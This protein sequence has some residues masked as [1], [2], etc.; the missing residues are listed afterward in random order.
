MNFKPIYLFLSLLL[1]SLTTQAQKYTQD[2]ILNDQAYTQTPFISLEGAKSDNLTVNISLKSYAP[3]PK[4]QEGLTGVSWATTYAAFSIEKNIEKGL[5]DSPTLNELAYSPYF[6]QAYLPVSK[7]DARY[8]QEINDA[9]D[10]L[11][12]KG[13]VNLSEYKPSPHL[14]P[15]SKGL[16]FKAQ[17]QS[18]IRYERLFDINC[19]EKQK[20]DRIRLM[21][22][23]NHPVILAVNMTGNFKDNDTIWHPNQGDQTENYHCLVAIGYDILDHQFELMNSWG[24]DWKNKGFCY[25]NETEL[26]KV[27]RYAYIIHL[28]EPPTSSSSPLFTIKPI[29]PRNPL[30][31][32]HQSQLLYTSASD[33]PLKQIYQ[34]ISSRRPTEAYIYVWSIDPNGKLTHHYPLNSNAS[35]DYS[36]HRSITIP[37]PKDAMRITQKG[38]DHIFILY[39]QSPIHNHHQIAQ[40]LQ[41]LHQKSSKPSP[42]AY[43][44]VLK[45]QLS[46][47]LI[48]QN[49]IQYDANQISFTTQASPQGDI[50]PIIL[51]IH[52]P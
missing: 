10:I 29:E 50:V 6:T 47:R 18:I 36:P 4:A 48:P 5:T 21:L 23:Q 40:S 42:K 27:C 13:A 7:A 41:A 15:P 32:T 46:N 12:D 11:R 43:L 28:S 37:S 51:K 49:Q 19:S 39:A 35:T 2:L 26:A 17:D 9:L 45:S 25:V 3:I 22:S 34:I 24:D 16:Q 38:T 30:S 33:W 14:E 8:G 44:K 1:L 31:F 52:A 20:V